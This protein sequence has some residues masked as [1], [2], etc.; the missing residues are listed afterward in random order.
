MA[1]MRVIII[2]V[3][4]PLNRQR[5]N[6]SSTPVHGRAGMGLLGALMGLLLILALMLAALGAWWINQPLTLRSAEVEVSVEAGQSPRAIA[7]AWTQAGVEVSPRL[8]YE[9]FRWSGQAR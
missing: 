2:T 1:S 7:Q 4:N 9:W 6:M 8:L 5:T 3:A